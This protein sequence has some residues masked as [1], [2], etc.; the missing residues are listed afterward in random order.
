MSHPLAQEWKATSNTSDSGEESP[1]GAAADHVSFLSTTS[2]QDL[3]IHARAN[4]SFDPA[5][6]LGDRGHGVN[7]FNAGKLNNYLHGLNKRLQEENEGLVER[8][9][10]YEER[11]GKFETGG[12]GTSGYDE[13][14]QSQRRASGGGRRVIAGPLGLGAVAE[15]DN[16]TEEKAELE[17]VI[18][19]LTEQLGKAA[20]EKE[21]SEQLLSEEKAERARDREK[22][23]ERMGE[24]ERGVQDIVDDIYQKLR[25][26]EERAVAAEKEKKEAERRVEEVRVERDVLVERVGKAEG[27][28]EGNQDLGGAVNAANE[29][30]SNVL[31]DLKNANLQIRELEEEAVGQ[32]ERIDALERELGEEKKLVMELEEEL[33]LKSEELQSTLQRIDSLQSEVKDARGELQEEKAIVA[34]LERANDAAVERIETLEELLGTTQERLAA[35]TEVLDQEREKALQ[36]EAEADRANQ[37]AAELEEAMDA[38]E[39]KMRG[40]EEAI[41]ALTTKMN[42]LERELDRSRSHDHDED[43]DADIAALEAELEDAHKQ[44][45]RLNVLVSQSPAR[46]AVEKAKDAKIEMLEQERDD[47]VERLKALKS[48]SLGTPGRS[49]G[50]MGM[51]I[52]PMHRH[53][54]N[55]SMK[56]PKT[57]G[58][59]LREVSPSL[60]ELILRLNVLIF[61]DSCRGCKRP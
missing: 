15:A 43:A 16:W 11:L 39:E 34:E 40:D 20:E 24:V 8:L 52:S 60:I 14:V 1:G 29:R 30:V 17:E 56:S 3:V 22:W 6:G 53:I 31:A 4:T 36:F 45:A 61:V 25:A 32:D 37:L 2:S 12:S 54:L 18:S 13:P 49:F 59:P 38:G 28:L 42:S 21:A 26:S 41:A 10:E 5:M 58:A 57:P 27:A 47:L 19:E 50:G 9:R 46:K 23:R 48:N 55:L 44:I 7:R 33:Q 35:T 51:G